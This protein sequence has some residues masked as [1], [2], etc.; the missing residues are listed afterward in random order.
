MKQTTINDSICKAFLDLSG[1]NCDLYDYWIRTLYTAEGDFVES[2]WNESNL[3]KMQEDIE[4]NA[5]AIK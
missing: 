2:A 4:H 5:K 1:L 3:Q